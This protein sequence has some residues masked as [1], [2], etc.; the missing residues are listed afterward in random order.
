MSDQE[1]T[2]AEPASEIS[3]ESRKNS[4][5]LGK[6]KPTTRQRLLAKLLLQHP[7]WPLCRALR[8]AGYSESECYDEP[9]KV[10]ARAG[11]QQALAEAKPEYRSALLAELPPAE[12][13]QTIAKRVRSDDERVSLRA[14]EVAAEHAG[15]VGEDNPD[16]V[17]IS[18]A[19]VRQVIIPAI[20]EDKL[21]AVLQALEQVA[22]SH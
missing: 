1:R 18:V 22:D 2:P 8:T 15:L 5:K 6:V 10:V 12:I 13:A 21:P 14:A 3:P 17:T 19:L 20:S 9:G 11:C 4:A 7:D 16:Y